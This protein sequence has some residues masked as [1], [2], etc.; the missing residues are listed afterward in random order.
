MG[1]SDGLH[2]TANCQNLRKYECS[3]QTSAI[4]KTLYKI[5]V[6]G[7]WFVHEKKAVS[8]EE[9]K[10]DVAFSFLNEDLELVSEVNELIKNRLSTF[11][12][13]ERQN[14]LVGNDG[15]EVFSKVFAKES[16]VVVIFYRKNWGND[17]FTRI[18]KMQ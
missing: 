10:Y 4:R 15:E 14:K 12:Y 18:E 1:I 5:P 13:T 17:R 9:Y 16:R 7:F 3:N 6:F 2:I 8:M 11:I